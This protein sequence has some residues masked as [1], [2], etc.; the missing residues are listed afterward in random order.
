MQNLHS[1]V[2]KFANR[3]CRVSW[4]YEDFS[5]V[6]LCLYKCLLSMGEIHI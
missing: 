6:T 3:F 1:C 4:Y 2:A 5:N